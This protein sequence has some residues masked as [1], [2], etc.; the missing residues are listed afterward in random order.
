MKANKPHD[1]NASHVARVRCALGLL[2][3]GH[4]WAR[5][6]GEHVLIGISGNE[7][8]AR[9]TPVGPPGAACYGLAF[10]ANEGPKGAWEPMLLVD[11]INDLVE[12]ALV[13]EGA[14]AA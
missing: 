14:L 4:A 6:A 13:A 3:A 5:A 12:H 10:R 2:H 7:A 8:F 1:A 11:G 9:I